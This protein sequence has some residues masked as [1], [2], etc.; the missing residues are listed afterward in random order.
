[1]SAPAVLIYLGLLALSRGA[2]GCSYRPGSRP[3][4][5]S[6]D[7]TAFRCCTYSSDCCS[8]QVCTG[9]G[10]A[11][12]KAPT[13]PSP[14][15][16]ARQGESCGATDGNCCDGLVCGSSALCRR[17]T[18][19]NPP[20]EPAAP[21]QPRPQ[22]S[23][24]R[25]P[26][27]P[28][29]PSPRSSPQP[30]GLQPAPSLAVVPNSA[31]QNPSSSAVQN[32]ALVGGVAGGAVALAAA[33]AGLAFMAVRRRRQEVLLAAQGKQQGAEWEQGGGVMPADDGAVAG[34][35][36]Q[37]AGRWTWAAAISMCRARKRHWAHPILLAAA[38]PVASCL[39]TLSTA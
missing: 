23:P 31:V 5:C 39:V 18:I 22:P 16:C 32:K 11:C 17:P 38:W 34:G 27:S 4:S 6:E 28:S 2:V 30:S 24:P 26:D 29:Q 3:P 13:S 35:A 15:T 10:G 1:M 7:P 20:G 14:A 8:G 12:V 21:S 37:A 25:R 36:G 9:Y 19:S 33:G